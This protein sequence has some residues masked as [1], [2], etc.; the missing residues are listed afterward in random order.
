MEKRIKSIRTPQQALNDSMLN[1][2]FIEAGQLYDSL[3]EKVN[4]LVRY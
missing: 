1:K 4:K 3:F 2:A